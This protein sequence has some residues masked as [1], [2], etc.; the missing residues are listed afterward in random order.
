VARYLRQAGTTFSDQYVE[1]ALVA[2]PQTAG[3][4]VELFRARFDPERAD[5]AAA[6]AD[7]AKRIEGEIDAVAA[8]DQ[9]R[10]LR[11]FL[12]VIQA[13]LRTTYF[14]STDPKPYLAFK[15]DPSRLP[16]LPLPRPQF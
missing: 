11:Q 13:M 8:L 10:I 12:A 4:L 1:E 2:H 7:V 16:W 5:D 15:L 3:L 14:Q 6:A 9:D